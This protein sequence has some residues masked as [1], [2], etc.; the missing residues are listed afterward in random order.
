M[1]SKFI[2]II[3]Y[4]IKTLLLITFLSLV[5]VHFV[6]KDRFQYISALYYGCPLP[7]IIIFGL[8]VAFIFRKRKPLNYLLLLA[9]LAMGI[10]YFTHYFGTAYDDDSGAETSRILFWNVAQKQPMPTDLLIKH[11]KDS[12][13]EI[14][15]LVE[16][17]DVSDED[18]HILKTALP[19]YQFQALN[20]E[21]FIGVKGTIEFVVFDSEEI[22]YRYN[23]LTLK[24]DNEEVSVMIAD[25]YASPLLNKEIPLQ[26][27]HQ[28]AK[29]NKTDI[30]VGDFNTPYESVFFESFKEDFN[31]FHPYSLG[32]SSTWPIP[33]PM[34]EIDQIWMDKSFQPIQ[35]EK[36]S[37]DASDHKL[38]IAEYK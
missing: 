24:I 14:I 26:I 32:L 28:V 13:A 21:M 16:A 9:L 22:I 27:I 6:V 3:L 1:I 31:S 17:I 35:M 15:A 34:I 8:M 38:L 7:I 12:K 20:G 2:K 33:I 11:I 29:E 37:Y 10:Y 4:V 5:I 18:L 19:E 25:V 36:F 30:L 23:Y